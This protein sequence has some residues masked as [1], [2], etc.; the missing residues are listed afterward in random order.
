MA[1]RKGETPR[2]KA[3]RLRQECKMLDFKAKRA[4]LVACTHLDAKVILAMWDF[5]EQEG[6]LD[7][8]HALAEGKDKKC[9]AIA[10]GDTE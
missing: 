2:M 9:K 3:A 5:A 7:M 10:N 1:P 6:F 8:A 4:D